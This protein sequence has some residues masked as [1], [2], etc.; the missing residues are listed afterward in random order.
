[1]TFDVTGRIPD[2]NRVLLF[3]A[4]T[5]P[6]KRTALVE[7]LLARPEWVE[8]WTMFFGDRYRN[9]SANSQIRR[10]ADGVEAFYQYLKGALSLNK[11]YNLIAQNLIT[12]TGE[13][14]R[15]RR[16]RPC[17]RIPPVW[18]ECLWRLAGCRLRSIS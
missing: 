8:K 10:Y 9:N 6:N 16:N 4:S 13:G 7:E 14:W 17:R 11:P 12:A 18:G 5:N 1:M 3:A 2:P 15:L